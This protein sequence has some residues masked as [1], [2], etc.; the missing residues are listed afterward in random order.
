MENKKGISLSIT[1]IVVIAVG[2]VVLLVVLSYFVGG[3]GRTGSTLRDVTS[4]A[5]ATGGEEV[6]R[7]MGNIFSIWGQG[8]N[9][10]CSTEDCATGMVCS[11]GVCK[12]LEGQKCKNGIECKS[13]T[14]TDEK[15]AA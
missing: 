6:S 2:V 14:C 15:C 9:E 3:F 4:E 8:V 5:E 13:G 10:D 7:G 1:A 11:G 12:R